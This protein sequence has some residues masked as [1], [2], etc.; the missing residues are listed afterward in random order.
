MSAVLDR[1]EYTQSND[2][3]VLDGRTQVALLSQ[4]KGMRLKARTVK[5]PEYK[6]KVKFRFLDLSTLSQLLKTHCFI[7]LTYLP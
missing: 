6:T 5:V 2:S 1:K 3:C 7:L 4:D